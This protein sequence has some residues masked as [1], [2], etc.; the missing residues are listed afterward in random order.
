MRSELWAG[1]C[2][3]PDVSVAWFGMWRAM[4]DTMGCMPFG[5]AC[6]FGL[7]SFWGCMPFW[8]ACFLGLRAFNHAG[9][10]RVGFLVR[11]RTP[12]APQALSSRRRQP[13]QAPHG[14]HQRGQPTTSRYG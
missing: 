7:H 6:L 13:T 5:A 11:V 14:S 12:S 2:G 1:V 4:S 9:V 8:V 10:C 3:K